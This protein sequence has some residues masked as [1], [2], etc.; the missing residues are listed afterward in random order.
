MERRI[1]L[2][3]KLK[4]RDEERDGAVQPIQRRVGAVRRK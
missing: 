2:A 3:E 1:T 4:L